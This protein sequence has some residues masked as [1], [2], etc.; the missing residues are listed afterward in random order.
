LSGQTETRQVSTPVLA[1]AGKLANNG[2]HAAD[3]YC[4]CGSFISSRW[5][6]H[7]ERG[8]NPAPFIRMQ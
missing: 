3:C 7:T 8:G 1:S 2:L 5:Q 6:M 4:N